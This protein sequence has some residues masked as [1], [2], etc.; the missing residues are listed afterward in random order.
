MSELPYRQEKLTRGD[1]QKGVRKSN[2]FY[3]MQFPLKC[4][5]YMKYQGNPNVPDKKNRQR[6]ILLEMC[7]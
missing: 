6:I 7:P 1:N 5:H 4:C 2:G 3:T